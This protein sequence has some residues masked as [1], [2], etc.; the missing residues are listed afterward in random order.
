[1]IFAKNIG[2]AAHIMLAWKENRGVS[3]NSGAVV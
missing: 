3:K 2:S 1:M